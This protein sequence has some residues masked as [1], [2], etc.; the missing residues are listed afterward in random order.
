MILNAVVKNLREVSNLLQ[1]LSNQEYTATCH[2]LSNATIGEH[3]RHILEMF[4]CLLSQYDSGIINY[5]NRKRDIAIQTQPEVALQV[6]GSIINGIEKPNKELLLQIKLDD[7]ITNVQTNY[8]REL[9]YNLDHCVH[10]QALIKVAITLSDIIE[11]DP[12]FGVA[13]STL[14]YRKQCVQ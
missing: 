11:I 10:H 7:C 9:I 14:E 8:H 13:R 3:T 12:D 4:Q 6:I 5:D 2:A 1:K